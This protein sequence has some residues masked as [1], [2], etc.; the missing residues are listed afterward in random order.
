MIKNKWKLAFWIC[1]AILIFTS[2]FS[3][4][5]ILDQS[6]TLTYIEESYG[7][8]END[9]IALSIIINETDFSKTQIKKALKNKNVR[10]FYDIAEDTIALERIELVF[11]LGKLKQVNRKY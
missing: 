1:L 6:V 2:L 7:E 4:Y 10:E 8:T 3:F 9:L 11:Y 5:C